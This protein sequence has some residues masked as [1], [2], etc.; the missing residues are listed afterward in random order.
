MGFGAGTVVEPGSNTN[1]RTCVEDPFSHVM[2]WASAAALGFCGSSTS[3]L[4]KL[5]PMVAD[6]ANA[7][8]ECLLLYYKYSPLAE[9]NAVDAVRSWYQKLCEGLDLRGRVRV[10]QDGVNVTIKGHAQAIQEHIEAVRMHPIL[11]N[12]EAIDFKV[13]PAA[14][15]PDSVVTRETGMDKLSVKACKEVVSL[16]PRGG[17]TAAS[18]DRTAA[19]ASAEAF[20]K[21]L[22]EAKTSGSPTVLLDARNIYESRIGQFQVDGISTLAPPIRSFSD[23]PAWIDSNA[24]TLRGKRVLM[25]CTG[26]VRCERA[27]AYLRSKGEGFDDVVQLFG[28][29]QR[30]MECYPEGGF[31]LGK[32]F[33]FDDRI[34][35][36]SEN[37]TVVGTCA[38]CTL[39][40]DDYSA[41][42]R[43]RQCRMLLLLCQTCQ[44]RPDCRDSFICELC[45]A[46]GS[47]GESS[48]TSKASRTGDKGMGKADAQARGSGAA[49]EQVACASVNG[50]G[51]S[52]RLRILCFHGF[53]QNADNFRGRQAGLR[54]RLQDVAELV[55][56]DAPHLLPMVY[57]APHG[58]GNPDGS[59][60][61][62]QA[63]A[64]PRRSPHGTL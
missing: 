55:F 60:A 36:G 59:D 57:K 25:Y 53:R 63:A 10:A 43:C 1:A 56:L 11:G 46:S 40:S 37:P 27:S 7:N 23:L 29:I 9:A 28:G 64:T 52:S 5:T 49:S 30:Y 48:S 47:S 3:E 14:T 13:A 42:L 31:F 39:P 17:G 33:V 24:A 16:G 44:S 34:A 62:V 61:G 6:V 2:N 41:R 58:A 8:D 38:A 35:V 18:L 15:S 21:V 20:H 22:H 12:G 26:G 54:R 50:G 4:E 32:N 51:E 45:K 19:H